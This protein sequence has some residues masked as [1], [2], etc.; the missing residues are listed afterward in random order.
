M[1]APDKIYLRETTRVNDTWYQKP[2]NLCRNHEYIRKDAILEFVNA[3]L[4]GY[5]E[6]TQWDFGY[7]KALKDII[8]KLNLL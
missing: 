7:R 1:N 3:K 5:S 8:D 4:K 2:S 6:D